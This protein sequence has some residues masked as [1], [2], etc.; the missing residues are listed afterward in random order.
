MIFIEKT[1][2][3]RRLKKSGLHRNGPTIQQTDTTSYRDAR[4]HF[5]IKRT[6]KYVL[7]EICNMDEELEEE[8]EVEEEE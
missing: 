2:D 1:T 4:T 8:K 3:F 6:Q 7:D 5:K